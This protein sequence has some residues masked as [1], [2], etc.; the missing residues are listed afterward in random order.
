M[1]DLEKRIYKWTKDCLNKK[2]LRSDWADD[3][4]KRAAET[5]TTLF[6]YYCPHCTKYHVT[7]KK[8]HKERQFG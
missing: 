2:R 1:S 6:K 8:E 5:G 4:I 3:V 7:R